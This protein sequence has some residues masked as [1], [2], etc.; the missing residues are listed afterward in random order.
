MLKPFFV[1]ENKELVRVQPEQVVFLETQRNY[2][3]I[4]LADK[5]YYLVRSSLST[6]L[7]KLPSDQFIKIHRSFVVSLHYID[8]I[9][10]DHLV[11][12]NEGLPIGKQYYK[13]L[14]ERLNVIE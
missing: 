10:T 8:R 12:G 5:K 3:K 9:N 2:T 1:W 14:I 6:A 11:V 7:K 4:Y 13:S